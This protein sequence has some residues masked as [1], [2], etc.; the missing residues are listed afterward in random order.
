MDAVHNPNNHSW[1][2][3]KINLNEYFTK[4]QELVYSTRS[5]SAKKGGDL[6]IL[7]TKNVKK[8]VETVQASVDDKDS[9]PETEKEKEQLDD[10]LYDKI[11]DLCDIDNL[12]IPNE[13]PPVQQFIDPVQP[14]QSSSDRQVYT[15][16]YPKF[17]VNIYSGVT[18]SNNLLTTVNILCSKHHI[19]CINHLICIYSKPIFQKLVNESYRVF[20]FNQNS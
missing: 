20:L 12:T 6:K 4:Y 16:Q 19:L 9:I 14:N 5:A 15:P 1:I 13:V 3:E 8:L 2:G 10:K 7:S 17:Q 18:N 11:E